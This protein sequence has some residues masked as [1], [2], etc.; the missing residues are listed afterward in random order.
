MNKYIMGAMC[1]IGGAIGGALAQHVT[2]L[3]K[4][5]SIVEER[6]KIELIWECE[7]MFLS[8]TVAEGV[9]YNRFLFEPG[10]TTGK[11]AGKA[12][13]SDFARN[14][15]IPERI[16]HMDSMRKY[17]R[18]AYRATVL[19]KRAQTELENTRRELEVLDKIKADIDANGGVITDEH[20]KRIAESSARMGYRIDYSAGY[21]DQD[22][23]KGQ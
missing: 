16:E 6:A 3:P 14:N 4:I 1:L 20:R 10:R 13:C 18:Q 23:E 21:F 19:E 7:I 8:S 22:K 11:R 12:L 17:A 9:E 5:E 2:M 15:M